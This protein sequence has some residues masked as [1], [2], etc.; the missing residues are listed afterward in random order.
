MEAVD[1][2]CVEGRQRF[3]RD[4]TRTTT[5]GQVVEQGGL[6]DSWP[7]F[8][9]ER[10][11]V[12]EKG[13]HSTVVHRFLRVIA[14]VATTARLANP[15]SS[16]TSTR[17][18]LSKIKGGPGSMRPLRFN[19][20]VAILSLLGLQSSVPLFFP[21]NSLTF[22]SLSKGAFEPHLDSDNRENL[23]REKEVCLLFS[24]L[25]VKIGDR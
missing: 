8:Q 4:Y 5:M 21:T 10:E 9:G 1:D 23:I 11:K 7:P 3:P 12:R 25:F 2:Y 16:G 18:D 6:L 14:T 22:Y 20:S 17:A 24:R 13:F 19:L 15:H